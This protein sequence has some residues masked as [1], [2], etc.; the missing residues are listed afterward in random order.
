MATDQTHP[1]GV[2]LTDAETEQ[3][4]EHGTRAIREFAEL[5]EFLLDRVR[6]QPRLYVVAAE[7]VAASL[8]ENDVEPY[9]GADERK[10]LSAR[11]L[12][13]LAL[14]ANGLQNKT[15]AQQ[16]WLSPETVKAHMGRI[17]RKLDATSRTHAVAIA[18]RKGL[19]T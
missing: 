14:A 7:E 19:I 4:L 1:R 17:R 15:M 13:V 8:D 2:T 3:L 16:L 18:L 12:E 11:E 10:P 6:S 9:E 5:A